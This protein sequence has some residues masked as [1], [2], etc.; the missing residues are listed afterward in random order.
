MKFIQFI[1]GMF[2]KNIPLK[3]IALALAGLCVIVINAAGA[4][5]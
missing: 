2:T 4:G 5:I 3:L 1:K